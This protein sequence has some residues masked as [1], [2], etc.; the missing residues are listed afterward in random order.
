MCNR[1]ENILAAVR[2][3]SHQWPKKG[4]L[5]GANTI[6]HFECESEAHDYVKHQFPYE[7]GS[8]ALLN[9]THLN[10]GKARALQG[11]AQELLSLHFRADAYMRYSI[12]QLEMFRAI[13]P[14]GCFNAPISPI[15]LD[16]ARYTIELA[17]LYR[18]FYD[19]YGALGLKE[20][21]K[22]IGTP[23]ALNKFLQLLE[24]IECRYRKINGRLYKTLSGRTSVD[25]SDLDEEKA[26]AGK[27]L[28]LIRALEE[29]QI[30]LD[31]QDSSS[32]RLR[33]ENKNS[34]KKLV[35]QFFIE[36]SKVLV[37]R[38]DLRLTARQHPT[39]E[40][41]PAIKSEA[42]PS[43][44]IDEFSLALSKLIRHL[45]SEYA[46]GF[47]GYVAKLEYAIDSGLHAHAFFF[48]NGHKHQQ[49]INIAQKIGE[50]WSGE[51][52]HHKGIYWNCNR[53]YYR[54]NGIGMIKRDDAEKRN[55]LI[56]KSFFYILKTDI[57]LKHIKK[58]KFQ[59]LRKTQL[60]SI[61]K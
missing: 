24:K 58:E 22:I 13:D 60:K 34:I 5:P 40:H 52:T 43:T 20:F 48:L 8:G 55:I 46:R 37:I 14:E 17:G 2:N 59:A 1:L 23:P 56:E 18:L 26:E 7:T 15:A 28:D 53:Q 4:V 32:D 29:I 16:W 42:K 51:I 11:A 41:D 21:D 33:R 30:L 50:L 35:D 44:E 45:K 12:R 38:I 54:N 57:L 27:S 10:T 36:S 49:D 61:K 39:I 6:S 3:L 47:M 19:D 31:K 9:S 25:K